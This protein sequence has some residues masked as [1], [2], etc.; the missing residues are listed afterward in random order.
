MS[1]FLLPLEVCDQLTSAIAR[2]WWSSDAERRGIHW[3]TWDKMC[4]SKEDGGTGFRDIHDFN[5]ALLAKQLWRLLRFSESLLARVLRGKYF[6]YSTPLRAGH[7][8]SPSYGWRSILAARPLLTMGILQKVHS[9]L[10]TRAWEDPWIPT[11]PARHANARIP[12]VHPRMTVSDFINRETKDWNVGML[13]E[14]MEPEDIPII[15]NGEIFEVEEVVTLQL[16]TI[17]HMMEDNCVNITGDIL[18]KVIGYCKKHIIVIPSG[19]GGSSEAEL[20]EWDTKFTSD[21]AQSTLFHLILAAS[22][23][24]I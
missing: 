14:Y 12:I 6:P 15:R 13:E 19:D 22:F 20:K 4:I 17:A 24:N 7:T 1:S 5:L 9:G 2:I 11:I 23:L 21:I 10:N 16:H 3:T 8:D 18:S